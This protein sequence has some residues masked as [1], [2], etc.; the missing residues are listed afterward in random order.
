MTHFLPSLYISFS[1]MS[2]HISLMIKPFNFF[3]EMLNWPAHGIT[4][5]YMSRFLTFKYVK[6]F[7]NYAFSRTLSFAY[8][9]IYNYSLATIIPFQPLNLEHYKTLR[10]MA[11]EVHAYAPDARIMTTYYCGEQFC[12]IF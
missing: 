7:L 10:N 1:M 12:H 3:Y 6:R 2:L 9:F 8:L 5:F 4:C 11:S